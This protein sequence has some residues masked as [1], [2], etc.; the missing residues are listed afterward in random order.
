MKRFEF[1]TGD[2]LA[3]YGSGLVSKVITVGTSSLLAP[4]GTRIAPS[5]VAIVAKTGAADLPLWVEST[6][7]STQPCVIRGEPVSGVQAHFIE[8]RAK[9]YLYRE[10]KVFVFRLTE[11][12]RLSSEEEILLIRIVKHLIN[13]RASYDTKGALIS[14]TRVFKRTRL[15]ELFSSM[16]EVDLNS[17]FCSELIAAVLM[18]LGRM[19]RD[20]PTKFSPASLVRELISQ[21]TYSI[22][23]EVRTD[24]NGLF[25]RERE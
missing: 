16:L 21:G 3:C 13:S 23:G 7:L 11:L 18:R 5:H 2:I 8:D 22:E 12:D 15:L 14:G 20:N 4:R 9:E 10:G 19:N 6:S 24:E 1:E 17:L 25:Y